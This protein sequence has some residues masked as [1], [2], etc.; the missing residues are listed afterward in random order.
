MSPRIW[1]RSSWGLDGL[2]HYSYSTDGRNFTPFGEPYQL[3]WGDYRGD[4]IGIFTFNNKSDTG[5][6][7]VDSF[8]YTYD[9]AAGRV[10]PGGAALLSR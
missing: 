6:V 5:Y 9:S 10:Q 1:L 7:D 2:S 4:R 8:I 3:A